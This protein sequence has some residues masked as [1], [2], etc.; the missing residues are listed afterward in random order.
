MYLAVLIVLHHRLQSGIDSA[1]IRANTL[2]APNQ[3][4]EPGQGPGM[5][6]QVTLKQA[7]RVAQVTLVAGIARRQNHSLTLITAQQRSRGIGF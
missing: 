6:N 1:L 3:V 7:R 4:G 2:Q 5:Q